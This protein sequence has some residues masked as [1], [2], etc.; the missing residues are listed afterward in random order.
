MQG[1]VATPTGRITAGLHCLLVIFA[2][3]GLSACGI[4]RDF[5]PPADADLRLGQTTIAEAV[6]RFGEPFRRTVVANSATGVNTAPGDERPTGLRPAMVDGVTHALGYV[7]VAD[8]ASARSM[9]LTF[10]NDRLIFHNFVSSFA[11][12]STDFDEAKISQ[13][14]RG[15][16][17]YGNL[18]AL[19]GRPS[20]LGVY[21]VVAT[22]GSRLVVY[23]F[24][25][26]NRQNHS[27]MYKRFEVLVDSRDIVVDY[28]L[29]AVDQPATVRDPAPQPLVVPIF[30]PSRR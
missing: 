11:N 7:Y 21:P 29:R 9:L 28:Y 17:T 5:P 14:R 10:W 25:Q 8:S 26:I 24:S 13:I 12:Q 1:C 4:G 27:V 22:R 30:V 16:T 23:Q 3:L 2:A 20:G 6:Q 15:A 18:V 19:L